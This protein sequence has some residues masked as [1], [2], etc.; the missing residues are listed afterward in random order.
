[1]D[2]KQTPEHSLPKE[3][4][5][6]PRESEVV[7]LVEE[8]DMVRNLAHM[9]LVQGGYV[10]LDARDAREALALC[11]GHQGP[12]D[13]LV[14]D[15]AIAELNGLELA[16]RA[17]RLRPGLKTM[18][19]SGHAEDVALK[20]IPKGSVLLQKPFTPIGL[21]ERVREALASDVLRPAGESRA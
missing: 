3:N 8:D 14:T 7:L 21:V 20:G 18:F 19:M 6:L 1:M 5:G 10:V 4:E 16:E 2:A 11:A 17:F 13:L 15:L 12:I 9:I